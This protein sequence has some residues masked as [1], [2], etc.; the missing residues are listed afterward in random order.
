M[1]PALKK[2]NLL[3]HATL[4]AIVIIS[5]ILFAPCN[6]TRYNS[7]H[8]IQ[9]L[10]SSRFTLP[11]D[12]YYWGQNRLGSLLP[13]ITWL[14]FKLTG[15]HPL[16]LIS[17]VLYVFVLVPTILI[18]RFI[19]DRWLIVLLFIAVFF[20]SNENVAL[21]YPGH[22]YS[23][24]YLCGVLFIF[25]LFKARGVLIAGGSGVRLLVHL[26]ISVVFFMLGIWLSEF[27]AL[28]VLI[29]L[30]FLCFE[31]KTFRLIL[32][33]KILGPII[34]ASLVYIALTTFLFFRIKHIAVPDKEYDHAFFFDAHSIAEELR[35]LGHRILDA[36]LFRDHFIYE[37]I[38]YYIFVP[39]TIVALLV[40]RKRK[41]PRPAAI[42]LLLTA[43]AGFI[44]LFFST[45]NFRSQICSRYY[46]PV[47]F[48][49]VFGLLLFMDKRT[50][51]WLP[52]FFTGAYTV[53]MILYLAYFFRTYNDP[54]PF[55][56]YAGFRDLPQGTLIAGY[57]DVYAI[58]SVA[59]DNLRPVPFDG[60]PFRNSFD[61]RKCL[62]SRNFYFINNDDLKGKMI[63]GCIDQ[64]NHRFKFTGQTYRCGNYEVMRFGKVY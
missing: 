32:D 4:A 21:L 51:G 35:F 37:N 60:D 41:E 59:Y 23:G 46:G 19:S 12:V 48:L 55:K 18:A 39:L 47:Y 7:D 2:D 33:R 31:R 29:P 5:F 9:T 53:F 64:L 26:S 49:T 36:L 61:K 22:P 17:F 44:L 28:L 13:M 25:F 15:L 45:W 20:P 38:F 34:L 52:K 56:R 11:R 54:P 50:S 1:S 63:N 3:L 8:A 10:M 43:L 58:C 24:E 57:W 14:L 27:S 42:A 40:S 16:Y 30:L 6:Y 62:A